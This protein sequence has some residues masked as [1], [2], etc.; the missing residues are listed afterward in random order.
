MEGSNEFTDGL[1][2]VISV[3][4][5]PSTDESAGMRGSKPP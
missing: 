2:V 3:F 5:S 1:M 4:G